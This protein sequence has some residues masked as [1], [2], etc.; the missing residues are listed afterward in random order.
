[1]D[2]FEVIGIPYDEAEVLFKA[3][4]GYPYFI[5]VDDDDEKKSFISNLTEG[6]DVGLVFEW[7]KGYARENEDF[8][9]KLADF[10]I[11]LSKEC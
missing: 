7:I 11:D 6:F 4:H 10:V 2:G 5:I 8:K 9:K 3:M 1:M